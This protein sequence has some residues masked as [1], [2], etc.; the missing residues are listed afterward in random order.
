[1]RAPSAP[2]AGRDYATFFCSRCAPESGALAAPTPRTS[3]P[4]PRAQLTPLQKTKSLQQTNKKPALVVAA[5]VALLVLALAGQAQAGGGGGGGW[6]RRNADGT[7]QS[8]LP[9][10]V[11]EDQVAA[12]RMT[13]PD[14]KVVDKPFP[15]EGKKQWGGGGEGAGAK[16]WGGAGG[17]HHG[18]AYKKQWDPSQ[19]R[20]TKSVVL[21]SGKVVA[22]PPRPRPE[23]TRGDVVSVTATYADG[24]TKSLPLPGSGSAAPQQRPAAGAPRPVS[25]AIALKNGTTI[26]KG[27]K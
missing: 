12:I 26:T 5:A 15:F 21:K 22:F 11:T 1:M 9:A 24:T 16:K 27:P 23:F 7:K 2:G 6:H 19:P 13:L 25:V 3:L 14:G 20:P 18:G 4:P 10:G 17:G 8:W